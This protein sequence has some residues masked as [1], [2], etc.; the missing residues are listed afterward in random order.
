MLPVAVARSSSDGN[1]IRYIL[2]VLWMT[3]CFHIIE[4]IGR[5]ISTRVIRPVRQVAAP[6][7]SL[8]SLTPRLHQVCASARARPSTKEL[9]PIIPMHMMNKELIPGS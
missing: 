2:P 8:P 7:R 1:A 5:I 4:R 6:G 3:S 9:F